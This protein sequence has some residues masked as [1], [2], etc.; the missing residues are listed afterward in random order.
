MLERKTFGPKVS[1]GDLFYDGSPS[2]PPGTFPVGAGLQ[3]DSAPHVTVTFD[4]PAGPF[5]L[6]TTARAEPI[7]ELKTT[8]C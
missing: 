8:Y 2:P 5:N 7:R 3:V 1:G 4:S 6:S